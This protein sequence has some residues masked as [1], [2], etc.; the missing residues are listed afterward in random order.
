VLAPYRIVFGIEIL[1]FNRFCLLSERVKKQESCR[2]SKHKI[3]LRSK[4]PES[5]SCRAFPLGCPSGFRLLCF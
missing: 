1:S 5:R 2:K 3:E 4:K